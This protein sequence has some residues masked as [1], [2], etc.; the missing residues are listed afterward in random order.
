MS[1]GVARW[2]YIFVSPFHTKSIDFSEDWKTIMWWTSWHRLWFFFLFFNEHEIKI[3]I[4][5]SYL[6]AEANDIDYCTHRPVFL[7]ST[8]T[9]ILYLYYIYMY[10]HRSTEGFARSRQR[11][12]LCFCFYRVGWK[13][14]WDKVSDF[15]S[16]IDLIF[17]LIECMMWTRNRV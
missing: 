9:C 10:L 11:R 7:S 5:G 3:V 16:N 8:L 4:I 17:S 1:G 13:Q 2:L 14:N 6:F 12:T 15:I